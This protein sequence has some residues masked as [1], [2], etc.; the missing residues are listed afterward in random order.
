MKRPVR[1]LLL[2]AGI[3][4]AAWIA[5][6]AGLLA[7]LPVVGR[8]APNGDVVP[9]DLSL[10]RPGEVV[11]LGRIQPA[12]DVIDVAAPIGDRLIRLLVAEGDVV[13]K[14]QSLA[15]LDSRELRALEAQAAQQQWVEAQARRDVER[16]LADARVKAA[17]LALR[18]AESAAEDIKAQEKSVELLQSNHEQALRDRERM[19]KLSSGLATPQQRERQALVVQQAEAELAAARAA[20]QGA[21][22]SNALALEAA[23]ADLRAAH[24]AQNQVDLLCAV[25]SLRIQHDLAQA[26]LKRSTVTAPAAGT[27]LRTFGRPG[28]LTAGGPLLQM[29]DLDRMVVVT[30]VHESDVKRIRAG[31]AVRVTSRA[32]RTPHDQ[33]GLGGSVERVGRV[34]GASLLRQVD[35][36]APDDRDVVQ[37]RVRLDP[38]ASREAAHFVNMQVEVRFQPDAPPL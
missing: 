1:L 6:A 26:R 37:V 27:V 7:R 36:F 32:F 21:R 18:K 11:A 24:A 31:Q 16:E 22:Q 13:A 10:P 3:A 19:A 20:L 5:H 30:D 34:V 38:E 35:P 2:I 25:E 4:I 15:E 33:R 12:G 28:E 9:P 17:E 14:D 29:A 23:E 8:G